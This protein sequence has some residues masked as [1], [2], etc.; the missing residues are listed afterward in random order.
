MPAIPPRT[1]V[2][3][4]NP[5]ARRALPASALDAAAGAMRARGW[6]VTIEVTTSR[7]DTVARAE[8]HARANVDALV[9]C[10]GDGTLLAVVNGVR[11]AG[12]EART[13]V[14]MIPVGTANVWAAE[15]GVPRDPM[16]ALALLENSER[17]R[18]D[19]GIARIGEGAAVPFLLVCGVGLDA[20]VVRAVENHPDWKR[21]LGRLAFGAPALRALA[22]WPAIDTRLA[23]DGVEVH[24]PHLLLA[25]A[26]NTSRYGGVASLSRTTQI[27]DGLIEVV[28]FEGGRSLRGRLALA[29]HAL[30]GHLDTRDVRGVTHRQATR[31]TLTPAHAMPIEVDGDAIGDC[32]PDAPLRIAVEHRAVTMIF[33]PAPT[34]SV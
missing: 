21:R 23:L 14:G 22:S 30:R 8:H 12:D 27:D 15:A 3:I 26:S 33:G 25:L 28:T 24:A 1:A 17:R 6:D 20:A 2:I 19:L 5:A 34:R 32:G 9:A 11:A 18:I 31:V 16:R 7:E 10:G 29:L 13:A 4:A